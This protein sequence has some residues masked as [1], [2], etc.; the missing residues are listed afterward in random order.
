VP[1][2]NSWHGL[3]ARNQNSIVCRRSSRQ[4]K[5]LRCAASSTVDPPPRS[6]SFAIRISRMRRFSRHFFYRFRSVTEPEASPV[7][8]E[9]NTCSTARA[10]SCSSSPIVSMSRA[11]PM[12]AQSETM[13][14]IL[15]ISTTFPLHFRKIAERNCLF[16][17]TSFAAGR[18]CNPSRQGTT[19]V[20]FF[21]TILRQTAAG[22]GSIFARSRRIFSIEHFC[23]LS[24]K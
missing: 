4:G 2:E 13:L 6:G 7:S 9:E 17:R 5:T 10:A 12:V 8:C 22:F 24:F 16:N 11:V 1:Y 23:E 15:R 14:K 20:E 19:T 18:R 21:I 3:C